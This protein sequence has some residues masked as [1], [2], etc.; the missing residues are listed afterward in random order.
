VSAGTPSVVLVQG[1]QSTV[2]GTR[3]VGVGGECD[4]QVI[5]LDSIQG[6]FSS[7][8]QLSFT[9]TEAGTL[10]TGTVTGSVTFSS[11]GTQ[12]TSGTYTIPT[13]CGFAADSGTVTGNV[14][15]PF[16]GTYSG[17]LANASGSSDAVGVTVSQNNF[18]LAVSGTDNGTPFTLSGRSVG[19]TFNVSGTIAGQSV[20]YI[21]LYDQTANEFLVFT[22][23]GGY[24]GT[25]ASGSSP[26]PVISVSVSAP[27]STVVAGQSVTFTAV[28]TGTT[29]K[30]VTWTVAGGSINGT[31]TASGVYTAPAIVPNPAMVTVTATSQGDI[32]KSGS[33]AITVVAPA[34]TVQVSVLP[35]TASVSD[36]RTQQFAAM[37]IGSTNTAVSWQ[38]NGVSGGS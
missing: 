24:L 11:D 10:G 9:L 20:Q 18:N 36:F 19:A 38:V 6:A 8:T 28:V 23:T 21:G 34:P 16:S 4:N 29:N 15:H 33:A 5:G 31:I 37:V 25:L 1:A 14:I 3:L 22:T 26:P 12:I 35:V 27:S 13:A 17:M 32:S 30:A 7:N 2:L